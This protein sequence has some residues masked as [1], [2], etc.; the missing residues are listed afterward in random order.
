MAELRYAFGRNWDEFIARKLSPEIVEKSAAHMAR[1]LKTRSLDGAMFLDIGCGSGIHSLAALRLGASRVVSFDYDVDSVATA[2]KVREWSGASRD[3]EIL[4]GSV[5]DRDF[6]ERLPKSDIVYSWGVLHHTGDMW[7]AVRNAAIPLKPEGEF[8][9]ALYS[10]DNYVDPPPDYW[11]RLKRAYNG[12]TPIARTLME[13]QYLNWSLIE[14]ALKAGNDPLKS[15]ADYGKRGMTAWTDVKDWLGGYPIEFAG[16]A[17]TREFCARELSL[18]VVNVL[19]GEGCTEFVFA[20]TAACPKWSA[21]EADR[22][23]ERRP[24]PRP[25]ENAGRCGY[26]ARLPE[27]LAGSGDTGADIWRS[28]VMLYENGSALGLAHAQAYTVSEFGGGRFR[29]EG[30]S[31]IFSAADSS[32]P[33]KNGRTYEYCARY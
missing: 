12:A 11:L 8:Y 23:A 5:L 33:N 10:S 3:W 29:H 26:R 17:Q 18:N 28:C 2:Q 22:S 25:F 4:Q 7:S 14:P 31:V 27:E 15:I 21:V 1:V 24:L 13:M 9:I 6:M 16:F 32:D 19:A 30:A 20:R